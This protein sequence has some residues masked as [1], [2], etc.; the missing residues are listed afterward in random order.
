MLFIKH[1]IK[2][3]HEAV[4]MFLDHIFPQILDLPLTL[5]LLGPVHIKA[6]PELSLPTWQL[7]LFI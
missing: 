5:H 3:W 4:N 2:K 1:F 7:I 6:T